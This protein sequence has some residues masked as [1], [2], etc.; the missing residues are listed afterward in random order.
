MCFGC[1]SPSLGRA[2]ICSD[3]LYFVLWKLM[4]YNLTLESLRLYFSNRKPLESFPMVSWWR[5][6]PN[7]RA[8]TSNLPLWPSC[9]CQLHSFCRPPK[10]NLYHHQLTPPSAEM[11]PLTRSWYG[12]SVHVSFQCQVWLV[13]GAVSW[14]H[15]TMFAGNFVQAKTV[16][17]GG[18]LHLPQAPFGTAAAIEHRPDI[19]FWSGVAA[20]AVQAQYWLL[21][22]GQRQGRWWE[23][24]RLVNDGLCTK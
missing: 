15:G 18:C 1:V 12:P 6:G 9:G 17:W 2:D 24:A 23:S 3:E 5:R 10:I 19:Q 8:Q 21:Y 11:I 7:F 22:L 20:G 13:D 14:Q 16:A 4:K